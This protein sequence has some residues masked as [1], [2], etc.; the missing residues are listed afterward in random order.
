MVAALFPL[1]LLGAGVDT[2]R[3]P[4]VP[5]IAMCVILAASALMYWLIVRYWTSR[6]QWVS[7]AQWARESGF[8][9]RP[10]RRDVL[11]DPLLVLVRSDAQ[12]RFHL[13]D[14][15]HTIVQFETEPSAPITSEAAGMIPRPR[16]NVMIR[17]RPGTGPI[18]G[19]RPAAQQPRLIDL[20]PLSKFPA[21]TLGDR[22]IVYADDARTG[23]ELA[24]SPLPSLLPPDMGLI[25]FENHVVLDFSTRPFDPIEFGRLIALSDQ[26]A[27]VIV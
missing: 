12:V 20:L 16:W 15:R 10:A 26:L 5:L 9:L 22:F 14:E 4:L 2:P 25:L 1:T 19:L 7:L 13:C 6:R 27:R 23:R 17:H 21:L 18:A 24:D 8:R 3:M 11:P